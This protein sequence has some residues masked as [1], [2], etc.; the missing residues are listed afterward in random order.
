VYFLFTNS[1]KL[2]LRIDAFGSDYWV[3]VQLYGDF[4]DDALTFTN[5]KLGRRDVCR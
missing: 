1:L 3:R 4:Y 2:G 5:D